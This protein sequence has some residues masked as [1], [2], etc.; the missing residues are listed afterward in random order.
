MDVELDLDVE[1][2]KQLLDLEQV[3]FKQPKRFRAQSQ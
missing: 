1:Q 3:I 2:V